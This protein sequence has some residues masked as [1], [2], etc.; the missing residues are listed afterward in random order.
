MKKYLHLFLLSVSLS[1]T[2][3]L[4]TGCAHSSTLVIAAKTLE[5]VG[6]TAES[7]VEVSAKMYQAHQIT[8][9]QA[10][11]VID[12]YTNKFQPAFR[13]AAKGVE[14]G[15]TPAPANLVDL[16]NQIVNLVASY[17]IKTP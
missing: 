13:L 16:A 15:V 3:V 5:G 1:L 4:V 2:P 6:Q 10:N 8:D 17:K 7:A 14:V 9:D 11:A 12:I